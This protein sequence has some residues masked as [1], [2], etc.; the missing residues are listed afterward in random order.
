M[1]YHQ[2]RQ[3]DKKKDLKGKQGEENTRIEHK[4]SFSIYY[5]VRVSK[6]NSYYMHIYIYISLYLVFIAEYCP[7][8]RRGPPA[9]WIS[10]NCIN[11]FSIINQWFCFNQPLAFK[12]T[13]IL[14]YWLR[15]SSYRRRSPIWTFF[16]RY[17]SSKD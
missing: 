8:R 13:E 3:K 6:L 12:S 7:P 10:R 4:V 5:V 2:W 15:Y 17:V 9:L 16:K 1:F 11:V 14:K